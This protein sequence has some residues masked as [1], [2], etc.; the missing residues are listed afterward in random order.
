MFAKYIIFTQRFYDACVRLVLYQISLR[1]EISSAAWKAVALTQQ[2]VPL[3]LQAL[4]Y[5]QDPQSRT[6]QQIPKRPTTNLST[7]LTARK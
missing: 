3:K 6:P 4:V 7:T 5:Y 1:F 2:S